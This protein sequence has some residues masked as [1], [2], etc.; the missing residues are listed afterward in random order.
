MLVPHDLVLTAAA[1][2]EELT[3]ETARSVI[4]LTHVPVNPRDLDSDSEIDSDFD[5]D[6]EEVDEDQDEFELDVEEG[7]KKIEKMD[8]DGEL[9]G[10]DEEVDDEEEDDEDEDD[11][12]DDDFDAVEQTVVLCS[13]IAGKVEQAPLNLT[14]VEGEAVLLEVTGENVVHLTGNYIKQ[15]THSHDDYD[16]EY[17]SE[18]DDYDDMSLD[19]EELDDEPVT[20]AKITEVPADIK[21]KKAAAPAVP[22]TKP[23]V[24][25]TAAPTTI[26]GK[27]RKADEITSSPGI[28][29]EANGNG[30]TEGLSKAQ[31]KKLAK[32]A[33]TEGG[34]EEKK[35]ETPVAA[36]KEVKTGNKGIKKTLPSGLVIEDVKVGD[37]PVARTGKRLGMRYIGKLESGKQFDANTA[38]KPFVFVLGKGE[39]IRG[40]DEGLAGMAVG[41][42]RRLT[43]PP[44]LAYG[45]QKI[46]GI[47]KNS[48]LKFD[49]KLVSV[50]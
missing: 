5:S 30:A 23:K 15:D 33:K 26:D 47:P 38:G 45:S 48:T 12:D 42:E 18:M 21:P 25:K 32:K 46:P 43:I 16:S 40:W 24:E 49:V 13:L 50:N 22:A 4:K 14:L 3:S 37:G 35:T 31:K 29:T 11:E 44:G 28:K 7:F 27:K 1:L 20:K 34:A 39:V 6:D 9:D 19:D 17:D 2:G 41:G 10:E 36:P 8:E